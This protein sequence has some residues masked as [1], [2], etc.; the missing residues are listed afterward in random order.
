[1]SVAVLMLMYTIYHSYGYMHGM[2]CVLSKT[3]VASEPRLDHIRVHYG[4][5]FWSLTVCCCGHITYYDLVGD[6][7]HCMILGPHLSDLLH[8]SLAMAPIKLAIIGAGPSSFYVASR[9]LSL[10]PQTRPQ[11]SQ[12]RIHMYD[13]LWAPYGLNRYGVA[14]DHPEVKVGICRV[15]PH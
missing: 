4:Y 7:S 9:L 15:Y 5:I 10:L 1:V 6:P 14:P 2:S 3:L 8:S 11:A 12:L 13:R